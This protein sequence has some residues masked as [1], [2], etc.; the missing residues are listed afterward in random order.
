MT[1]GTVVAG[2]AAVAEEAF[3]KRY[4]NHRAKFQAYCCASCLRGR[5]DIMTVA[6]YR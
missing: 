1:V 2:Y 3:T 6:T 5:I 4:G